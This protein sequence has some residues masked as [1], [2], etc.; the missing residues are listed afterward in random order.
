[1]I[2]LAIYK[3]RTDNK[4]GLSPY[5]RNQNKNKNKSTQTSTPA[6][7]SNLTYIN[8]SNQPSFH[9]PLSFYYRSSYPQSLPCSRA[10]GKALMAAKG[11]AAKKKAEKQAKDKEKA[12]KKQ[13]EKEAKER[14]KASSSAAKSS[15]AN[16]RTLSFASLTI[17]SLLQRYKSRV[18]SLLPF[19]DRWRISPIKGQ[20]F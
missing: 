11:K 13:A 7:T 18:S 3:F 2:F 19:R 8:F 15:R 14:E 5:G 10:N 9:P 12:E 1:M 16:V 4:L 6:F 20:R 17:H